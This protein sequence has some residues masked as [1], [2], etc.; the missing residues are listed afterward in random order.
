MGTI[1]YIF[2]HPDDESFGPAPVIARQRR[3]GHRVGLLTLTRGEATSQR[4]KYGYSKDEMGRVRFDEMR[5]VARVLDLT[6]LE[7]LDFPDGGLAELNPIDLEEAVSR[8]IRAFRPN[9]VVTYITHGCSGHPDHL[10]THAVVKRTFCD[11]RS[12][13]EGYLQR[14]A[15]FTLDDDADVDRPSHL[16]GTPRAEIDCIVRYDETDREK[17][18]AALA[19]YETYRDVVEVHRPLDTVAEGVCFVFFGETLEDRVH[20]LFAGLETGP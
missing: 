18:E 3:Q 11:L 7:V 13:G 12:R 8:H 19:A 14:L 2:P 20:D 17:G 10:V 5:E 1:L 4:K 16:R 9:V 6:E 15:F